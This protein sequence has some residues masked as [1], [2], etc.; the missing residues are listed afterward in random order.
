MIRKRP[1]V[2]LTL[3]VEARDALDEI[4]SREKETRSGMSEKLIR[5]EMAR[6]NILPKKAGKRV[7]K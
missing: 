1:V 6:R 5:A 7:P 2:A 3:S 4:A